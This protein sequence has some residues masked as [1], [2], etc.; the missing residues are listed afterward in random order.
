MQDDLW[1]NS[2]DSEVLQ[3]VHTSMSVSRSMLMSALLFHSSALA[4]ALFFVVSSMSIRLITI[5]TIR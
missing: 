5:S 3:H 2:V 1:G 4:F